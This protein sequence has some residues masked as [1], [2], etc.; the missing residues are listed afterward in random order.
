ME[1]SIFDLPRRDV[2]DGTAT[3]CVEPTAYVVRPNADDRRASENASNGKKDMTLNGEP[4]RER[5][6]KGRDIDRHP[7][8]PSAARSELDA[9]C[10]VIPTT[11]DA[12][13]GVPTDGFS[14]WDPARTRVYPAHLA[15][16][17]RGSLVTRAYGAET[18]A[19]AVDFDR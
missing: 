7:P 12:P 10:K 2:F 16:I 1:K 9:I 19:A 8:G 5:D 3:S 13:Q 14:K 18:K 15:R 17:G 11:P 4:D 6:H